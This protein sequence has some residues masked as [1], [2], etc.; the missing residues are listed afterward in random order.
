MIGTTR[1]CRHSVLVPRAPIR[2][3]DPLSP[4]RPIPRT[5][6]R[7]T[8]ATVQRVRLQTVM[9]WSCSSGRVS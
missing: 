3:G 7:I 8:P 6:P 9:R 4:P 1:L 2:H 5:S